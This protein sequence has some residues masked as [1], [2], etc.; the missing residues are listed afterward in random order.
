[1]NIT[2]SFAIAALAG[3]TYPAAYMI[4]PARASWGL[5]HFSALGFETFRLVESGDYHAAV[6]NIIGQC[7][8]RLARGICRLNFSGLLTGV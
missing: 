2:G 6:A 7:C 4:W 8:G 5:Y 3:L 1:V